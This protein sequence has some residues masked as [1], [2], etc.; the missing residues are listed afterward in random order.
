MQYFPVFLNLQDRSC[1]VIGAGQVAERKIRL[2]LRTAAQMDVVAPDCTEN[3][4]RWADEGRIALHNRTYRSSDLKNRQ[5]VFIATNNH[6]LNQQIFAEAERLGIWANVADAPEYCDFILP[7]IV[8]RGPVIAAISTS[9]RSPTLARKMRREIER[10]LPA[11][12]GRV[13]EWLSAHRPTVMDRFPDETVRQR[14]WQDLL[15]TNVMEM[16]LNG[17]ISQA[18]QQFNQMLDEIDHHRKG[19]VYLVGAGPGDLEL[20]TL[21]ALRLMQRADVVLYDRL[22]SDA[23]LE[24][25]RRDARRIYVG[26]KRAYHAVRQEEIN[27][28][29]IELASEGKRVLRLKGGDPFVFGRGGEEIAGLMEAGIPFQVVPGI[30]AASGCAAYAGIPLTHRDY[31]QSVTFVAGHLKDNESLQLD[32]QLLARPAQTVVVYM[33]LENLDQLLAQLLNHGVPKERPV[34]LIEEGTSEQQRVIIGDMTTLPQRVREA[35]VR[36]PTLII[37]GEV[38]RLHDSLRWK[39]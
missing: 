23:I 12:L 13:A 10:L 39:E 26:K 14:F 18:E 29:I 24:Q 32:W 35:Q 8:D 21:K 22:V 38:V 11:Q 16:I 3:I 1:L 28:M 25:V 4:L 37:I 33:G 30:T 27:Q 2:L 31:A 36:A 5:L 7:S 17:Q 9:G 19:E 34:A 6:R 15:D 20:L